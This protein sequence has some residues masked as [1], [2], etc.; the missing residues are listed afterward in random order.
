MFLKSMLLVGGMMDL[1]DELVLFCEKNVTLY[2]FADLR[3]YK[4]EIFSNE[5]KNYDYGISIGINIPDDIVDNLNHGKGRWK[6]HDAN[7]GVNNLLN[8]NASNIMKI[9]TRHGYEAVNVDSSYILP[10]ENFVGEISHKLVANLAGLGWIGKSAL[11][12]N[13]H[14]GPRVRWATILTNAKFPIVNKRM[15]SGCNSCSLCVESCPANAFVDLEFDETIPRDN[16]Y[17]AK[18]CYAYFEKLESEGKPS[19]C[20]IC[21]KV[22]PWGLKNKNSRIKEDIFSLD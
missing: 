8:N 2:G 12:I 1:Y 16:R 14:Y 13:P 10:G 20:G 9:I 5:L 7:V 21:V 22:C 17:D 3:K 11:F 4:E 18:A 6:Y 15:K 19:K